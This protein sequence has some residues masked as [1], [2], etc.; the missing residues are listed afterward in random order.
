VVKVPDLQKLIDKI[1]EVVPLPSVAMRIINY[2]DDPDAEIS[3]LAK[4][5]SMDQALTTEVLKLANSAYYGFPRRVS[6]ISEAVVILGFSTTRSVVWSVI[7]SSTLKKPVLGY[8]LPEGALWRHSVAVA[9]G[10]KLILQHANVKGVNMEEAFVAGLIH[11]IGKL[12]LATY[13]AGAYEE[14]VKVIAEGKTFDEAE[15]QVLGYDHAIVGSMAAEKWNLPNIYVDA[16]KYHHRPNETD[17]LM[18]K[19]VHLADYI[20]YSMGWGSEGLEGLN[21]TLDESVLEELGIAPEEID[22]LFNETLD[23]AELFLSSIG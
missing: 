7:L 17:N 23:Q 2:I 10:S 9:V 21:Y 22:V 18:A 16:I 12:L 13:V 5:I 11:D 4:L 15:R 14:I 20:A 1:E 8:A 3:Q 6:T 19:V